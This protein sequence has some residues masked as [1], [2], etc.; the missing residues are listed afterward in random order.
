MISVL[1]ARL[2]SFEANSQSLIE[3]PIDYCENGKLDQVL[4]EAICRS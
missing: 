1:P 2:S 4:G 3:C